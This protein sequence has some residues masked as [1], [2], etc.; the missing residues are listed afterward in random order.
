MVSFPSRHLGA[1]DQYLRGQE[2]YDA[3]SPALKGGRIA[4]SDAMATILSLIVPR[5]VDPMPVIGSC[6]ERR[7]P[8][9]ARLAYRLAAKQEMIRE[10]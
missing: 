10:G 5:V 3:A 9:G 6:V 1:V 2:Q 8:V 7:A 4:C